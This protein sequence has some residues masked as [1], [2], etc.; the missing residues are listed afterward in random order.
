VERR[1]QVRLQRQLSDTRCI[2]GDNWGVDRS[3]I[4]VDRG[5]SAEFV[6]E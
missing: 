6:I 2:R 3:G 1:G 4:W 5:C